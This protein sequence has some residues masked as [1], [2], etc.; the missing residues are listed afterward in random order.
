MTASR[1]K[2]PASCCRELTVEDMR[3]GVSKIRNHVI[4]RVFRELN[5]IE[6]WGSGMRRIFREAEEQGLPELE[7]MEVGM[8][9]RVVVYLAQAIRTGVATEQVTEQVKRLLECL[10]AGPL[11]VKE[12]WIPCHSSTVRR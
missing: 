3:Q 10:K 1:S 6:Q 12:I 9:P 8:R 7:I 5:L 4:A 2:A 11:G